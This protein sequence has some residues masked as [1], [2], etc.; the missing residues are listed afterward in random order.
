MITEEHAPKS[1]PWRLVEAEVLPK[2][3]G[4][5]EEAQVDFLGSLRPFPYVR[6]PV[7]YCTGMIDFTGNFKNGSHTLMYYDPQ[8]IFTPIFFTFHVTSLPRCLPEPVNG[9]Y[10]PTSVNI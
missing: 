7:Q 4:R 2:V 6:Y 10:L 8:D 9:P 1:G 5:E 3:V